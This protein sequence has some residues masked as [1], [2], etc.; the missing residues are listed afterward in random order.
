MA[1]LSTTA[2]VLHELGLATGF[3][4]TLFGQLAM[5]PAVHKIHSN[6]ERGRV[7]QMAWDRYTAVNA[8]SLAIMAGSWLVGRSYLRRTR[9]RSL[10]LAKDI[11]VSGALATGATS[12]VLGKLHEREV[13]ALN[14]PLKKG[15]PPRVWT[16]RRAKRLAL[17]VKVAGAAYIALSGAILVTS[18]LATVRR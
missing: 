4:G 13:K 3:G 2:W 18:A 9:Q 6:L 16:M 8:P 7:S 17:A 11:L 10:L 1:T 14:S 12:M 5:N 15:S